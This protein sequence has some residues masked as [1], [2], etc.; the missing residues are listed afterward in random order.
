MLLTIQDDNLG[1]I[2]LKKWMKVEGKVVSSWIE[3]LYATP[4]K[5]FFYRKNFIFHKQ[6]FQKYALC[7]SSI[8]PKNHK[9][10]KEVEESK[11]EVLLRPCIF[12]NQYKYSFGDDEKLISNVETLWMVTRQ[13]TQVLSNGLINKAKTQGTMYEKKGSKWTG[14]FLQSGQYTN[15]Y[16]GYS[17]YKEFIMAKLVVPWVLTS[18]KNL[19]DKKRMNIFWMIS[20]WNLQANNIKVII[21]WRCKPNVSNSGKNTFV[22]WRRRC[23]LWK[24]LWIP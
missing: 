11:V 9:I 2:D 18:L 1:T 23:Q 19:K 21:S 22:F 13:K 3:P 20:C 15:N 16:E 12:R 6:F 4:P 10:G 7:N 8:L 17:L 5:L 24:W 14:V